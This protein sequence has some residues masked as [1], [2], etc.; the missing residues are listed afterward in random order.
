MDYNDLDYQNEN[1][2]LKEFLK[3]F[4]IYSI[5]TTFVKRGTS[6]LF[7]FFINEKNKNYYLDTIRFINK[8]QVP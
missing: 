8:K 1:I 4:D 2:I 7:Y 5:K 3:N 6:D